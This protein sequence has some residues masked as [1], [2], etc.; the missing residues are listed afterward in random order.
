[1]KVKINISAEW[2][3]EQYNGCSDHTRVFSYFKD[4]EITMELCIT[5]GELNSIKFLGHLPQVAI[6]E[7]YQ[8]VKDEI[9]MDEAY[10]KV[11]YP[12]VNND[13]ISF[14]NFKIR[15]EQ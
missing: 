5:D 1:M 9:K 6:G 14:E 8:K 12:P 10:K 7:I 11:V 2:E 4:L 15:K 3:G 13:D